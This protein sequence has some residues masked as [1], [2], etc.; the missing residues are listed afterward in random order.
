MSLWRRAALW[1]VLAAA[2]MLACRR[3]DPGVPIVAPFNDESRIGRITATW[4]PA[5]GD[6]SNRTLQY[7][8]RVEN[9]L[10]DGLFVR[11]DHFRL[12]DT[13][14]KSLAV[15]TEKR[16]CVVAGGATEIVLQGKLEI[17]AGDATRATGFGVDHFGV[18]L[19]ERGRGIYREFLLQSEKYTAA[20]I[21]AE[22]DGYLQAPNCNR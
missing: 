12:Q 2:A 20:A 21:D 5:P 14:G 11:L 7:T 6:S 4:E 16:E 1:T 15:A 13:A 9:R 18:P 3:A 17:P 22:I 10:A 8:V 19:S